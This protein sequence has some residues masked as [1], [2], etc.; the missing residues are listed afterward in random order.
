MDKLCHK[1]STRL[2][3]IELKVKVLEEAF[4]PIKKD[5]RTIKNVTILVGGGAL[6]NTLSQLGAASGLFKLLAPFLAS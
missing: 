2:T 3:V 5:I 1:H 4:V 6:L